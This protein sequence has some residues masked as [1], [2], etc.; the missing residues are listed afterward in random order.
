MQLSVKPSVV[1]GEAF[2]ARGC[3]SCTCN[4]CDCNPCTCGDSLAPAYPAWRVSGYYVDQG[5]TSGVD[6]SHLLIISLAQPVLAGQGEGAWQEVI[7]VPDTASSEQVSTLLATFDGVLHS[8]PAEVTDQPRR[9]ASVYRASLSYTTWH[10]DATLSLS[11][12]PSPECRVRLGGYTSDP[13]EWLYDGPMA[14]RST[15]DTR[16]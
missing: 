13:R 7:L 4:P 15:F 14:V 5:D 11:F 9:Q 3:A 16:K 6:I 12:V 10:A 1:K 2:G 8:M